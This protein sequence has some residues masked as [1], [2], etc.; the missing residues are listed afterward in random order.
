MTG[1]YLPI[2]R[3]TGAHRAP[4]QSVEWE[5]FT[6]LLGGHELNPFARSID[7]LDRERAYLTFLVV[8]R[9]L[10]ATLPRCSQSFRERS[11]RYRRRPAGGS[12]LDPAHTFPTSAHLSGHLFPRHLFYPTG[13]MIAD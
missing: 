4:L 1:R 6:S 2:P 10:G 13:A 9:G 3:K 12:L 8:F 5:F 11:A 7:G